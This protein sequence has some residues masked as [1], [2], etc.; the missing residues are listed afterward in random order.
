MTAESTV[1]GTYLFIYLNIALM[2]VFLYVTALGRVQ[3]KRHDREQGLPGGYEVTQVGKGKVGH[4][5]R[6]S[7]GKVDR[8]STDKGEL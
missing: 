5:D 1:E 3:A 2:Y 4:G 8:D 7:K 6:R